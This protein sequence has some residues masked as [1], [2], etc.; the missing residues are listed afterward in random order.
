VK[1]DAWYLLR[2]KRDKLLQET[3]KYM[4]PDFPIETKT[5]ALYRDYRKYLRDLPKLFSEENIKTAK[6]KNFK[7]WQDF[8]YNGNY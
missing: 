2:A 6:V 4:L 8:R 3:D 7:E 5:R 1:I